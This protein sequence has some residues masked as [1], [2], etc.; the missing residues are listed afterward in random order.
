MVSYEERIR[1]LLQEID[2]LPQGSLGEKTVNGHTYTY[3]RWQENKKNL[4]WARTSSQNRL[5]F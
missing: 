2:A 5:Y 4:P 3:H 1:D